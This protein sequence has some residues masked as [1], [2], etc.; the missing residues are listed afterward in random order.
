MTGLMTGTARPTA[1]MIE[2]PDSLVRV[3]AD[4]VAVAWKQL[5]LKYSN[6]ELCEFVEDAITER[7]YMILGE[8]DADPAEE[9]REITSLQ[10]PVREGSIRNYNNEHPD[11]K[12]DLAFRPMKGYLGTVRNTATAAIFIECKPI[13][14][15]RPIGSTY[16]KNGLI[17]FVNGDYSWQVNR[18]M[19][20]GYVRNVSYLPSGLKTALIDPAMRKL[21]GCSGILSQEK[22]TITGD[23]VWST[24]HTRSFDLNGEAVADIQVDH[25]WLYPE[26]PCENNTSRG[27]VPFSELKT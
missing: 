4:M 19:M 10:S 14:Q 20:V 21:L 18:A 13:G 16:C 24:S 11:K 12:P 3:V 23:K 2:I 15:S 26:K 27:S 6:E 8:I 17:R 9:L 25:L 5:L 1:E 7:L 22:S